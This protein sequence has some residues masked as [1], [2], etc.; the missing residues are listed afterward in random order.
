M[1]MS[2]YF[3]QAAAGTSVMNGFKIRRVRVSKEEI[4]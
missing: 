3:C 4:N 2:A 1:L